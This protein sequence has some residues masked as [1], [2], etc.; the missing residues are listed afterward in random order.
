MATVSH[1]EV[2]DA[3]AD[4]VWALVGDF[5]NDSWTGVDITCDGAGVGAVRT[6]AMPG[7]D[8]V[9][10]C[11]HH[12]P[13]QRV[14]GYTVLTGNPFPVTDCHGTIVVASLAGD[15]SEVSWTIGYT[16]VEDPTE[17]EQ[18]LGRF[19]R[20]SARALKDFAEAA[21]PGRPS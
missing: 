15:R 8:V 6:V 1:I 17:V 10:R 20:A 5:G 2:I 14:L 11:D 9:E 3:S 12:D 13:G 21:R 19:V 7:G 18:S 16:T 4:E